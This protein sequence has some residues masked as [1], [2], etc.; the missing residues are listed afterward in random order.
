MMMSNTENDFSKIISELSRI[1]DVAEKVLINSEA[2]KKAYSDKINAESAQFDKELEE[3]IRK[4]LSD[5]EDDI[6]SKLTNSLN[7]IRRETDQ[8]IND[9]EAW[10][11]E[12]HNLVADE[13]VAE[14]IKE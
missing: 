10:Y 3:N 1:D 4:K 11:N 2:D 9:L 5:Y 7:H 12:N 8:A 6:E 13:I 14:L